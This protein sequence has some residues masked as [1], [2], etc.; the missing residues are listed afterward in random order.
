MIN[1]D[2][3]TKVLRFTVLLG[4]WVSVLAFERDAAGASVSMQVSTNS[5]PPNSEVSVRVNGANLS[6]ITH[7]SLGENSANPRAEVTHPDA[8][9]VSFK[10]PQMDPGNYRIHLWTSG[11]V[12]TPTYSSNTALFTVTQTLAPVITSPLSA[13]A[14]NGVA[15]E[16]QITASNFPTSFDA[17]GLP[18]GLVVDPTTGK[19]SGKP[20]PNELGDFNITLFASN[21]AGTR[22]AT[23]SLEILPPAPVINSPLTASTQVGKEFAY[24]IEASN[25]PTQYGAS[26]LPSG[27]SV[28]TST[29]LISGVPSASGTSDITISASNAGGKDQITLRLTVNP[30][31]VPKIIS[32]NTGQAVVG[33]VYAYQIEASNNPTHYSAAP[34]PPG[35]QLDAANGTISGVPTQPGT[36]EIELAAQNEFGE[37]TSVLTLTVLSNRP[38]L[39][40]KLLANG[41]LKLTWPTLF[42]DFVLESK[43]AFA[44]ADWSAVQ[45]EVGF[46]GDRLVVTVAPPDAVATQF[47]RLRKQ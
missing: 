39:Q 7:A 18:A 29:G 3:W 40:I 42:A 28:N 14:T 15:F 43:E 41:N 21:S 9:T 27:L 31:P 4:V 2:L 19:I 35:L 23:L 10:V 1:P 17:S 13:T 26:P 24:Q 11:T 22:N 16:Y 6:L 5:G 20:N 25:N 44:T 45:S 32:P 33:E 38:D 8:I 47:Y 12:G 46:E 36:F 30:S 37:G 34:L